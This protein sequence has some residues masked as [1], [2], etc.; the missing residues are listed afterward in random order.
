MHPSQLPSDN[1]LASFGR[2]VYVGSGLLT[3][4]LRLRKVSGRSKYA[5]PVLCTQLQGVYQD[6]VALNG[7]IF[8]SLRWAPFWILAL[9]AKALVN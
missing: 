8:R 5:F 9:S 4:C 2:L 6:D 1:Q 3:C 7:D